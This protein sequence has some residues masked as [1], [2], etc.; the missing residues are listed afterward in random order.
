MR[1]RSTCETVVNNLEK[2]ETTIQSCIVDREVLTYFFLVIRKSTTMATSSRNANEP[3]SVNPMG[4]KFLILTQR[5]GIC[6]AGLRV[7][8]RRCS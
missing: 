1:E 2:S 3:V 6:E 4:S 5:R 8:E 7:Q